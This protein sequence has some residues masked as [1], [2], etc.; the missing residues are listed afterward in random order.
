M[1]AEPAN[2]DFPEDLA[3]EILDRMTPAEQA[4]ALEEARAK[5][6][7]VDL[8]VLR[9]IGVLIEQADRDHEAFLRGPRA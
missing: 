5:G 4:E 7:T 9:A 8:L 2:D 3:R 6:V 1:S